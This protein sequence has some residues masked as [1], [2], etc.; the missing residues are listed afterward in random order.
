MWRRPRPGYC[1]RRAR[2]ES[3]R[4][5]TRSESISGASCLE[6]KTN[7][8]GGA[9]RSRC[10]LFPAHAPQLSS[11]RP[12]STVGQSISRCILTWPRGSRARASGDPRRG[13]FERPASDRLA[14]IAHLESADPSRG[15]PVGASASAATAAAT[16]QTMTPMTTPATMKNGA[17]D[18]R[19]RAA[20]R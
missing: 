10:N 20:H 12:G 15:G 16:A 19:E 13:V 4:R 9:S 3:A 5:L 8:P 2:L 6:A 1:A 14:Q 7:E 17:R 11:A 18:P